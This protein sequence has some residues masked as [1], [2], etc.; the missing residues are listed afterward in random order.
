MPTVQAAVPFCG[1]YDWTPLSS[2]PGF[3]DFL[4]RFGIMKQSYAEAPELY[5][6]ASPVWRVGPHPPPMFVLHGSFD[7]FA[8]VQ[9]ARELVARLGRQTRSPLVYAELPGAQHA[10]DIFGSPRATAAAEAVERFLGVIY[11]QW[12][13]AQRAAPA[14]RG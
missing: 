12:L 3:E 8:P 6:Q 9:Q 5:Q 13:R 14:T 10:F 11:G 1:I 2:R 7:A 4:Q